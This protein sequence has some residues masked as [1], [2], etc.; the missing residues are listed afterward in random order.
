MFLAE[1]RLHPIRRKRGETTD[2]TWN[3]LALEINE[4]R[5]RG[6]C[7]P[8]RLNS[9]SLAQVQPNFSHSHAVICSEKRCTVEPNDSHAHQRHNVCVSTMIQSMHG[10]RQV[11]ICGV[12]T[13]THSPQPVQTHPLFPPPP[14]MLLSI[15]GVCQKKTFLLSHNDFHCWKQTTHW[16]EERRTDSHSFL[17][18]LTLTIIPIFTPKIYI[19]LPCEDRLFVLT[20]R[21]IQAHSET[22]VHINSNAQDQHTHTHTK[23]AVTRPATGNRMKMKAE[24]G[25]REGKKREK[26]R[27]EKSP[28]GRGRFS[29]SLKSADPSLP[30]STSTAFFL[31]SLF[32]SSIP[33]SP[34]P[35][36]FSSVFRPLSQFNQPS[37]YFSDHLSLPSLSPCPPLPLPLLL[38]VFLYLSGLSL[39]RIIT[40]SVFHRPLPLSVTV[41]ELQADRGSIH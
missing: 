30:P 9:E 7:Q 17:E 6:F 40:L 27:E 19:F 8:C 22:C 18:D 24:Q 35:P 12:Q 34:L 10:S 2:V 16:L 14:S 28:C 4:S 31:A 38:P 13:N 11:I 1:H 3:L 25:R 29:S 5:I 37:L 15:T 36:C 33:P 21:V 23:A 39:F 32:L 26:K 20:M 41:G